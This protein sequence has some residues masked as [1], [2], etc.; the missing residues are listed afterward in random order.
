MPHEKDSVTV[1]GEVPLID[2]GDEVQ[3][4][5]VLG[6][7]EDRMRVEEPTPGE[8][9]KLLL[10][11]MD[12][13]IRQVTPISVVNDVKETEVHAVGWRAGRERGFRDAGN[14][15]PL[16]LPSTSAPASPEREEESP[17]T[18]PLR[19]TRTVFS[20]ARK[21]SGEREHVVRRVLSIYSR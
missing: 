3:E 13:E 19:L 9:L 2:F 15:S 5:T 21:V 4:T 8:K 12:A 14:R 16:P 10:S 1:V 6:W 18:P 20:S 11:Q 7:G 17:P